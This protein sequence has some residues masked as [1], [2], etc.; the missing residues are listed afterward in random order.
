MSAG[1]PAVCSPVGAN[2]SIVEDGASGYFASTPAE[3]FS[4]L[5]QLA[6]DPGLRKRLGQR[7]R[8]VVEE[9]YS[10]KAMAPR[11]LAVLLETAASGKTPSG[12]GLS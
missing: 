8:E 4:R 6:Q 9:R 10:L 3:W 12:R 7:G 5:K 11:L 2:L 1:I